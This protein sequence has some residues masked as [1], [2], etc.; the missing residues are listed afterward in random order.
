MTMKEFIK[1]KAELISAIADIIA[2]SIIVFVHI[3]NLY[4]CIVVA[5]T[6]GGANNFLEFILYIFDQIKLNGFKEY[7]KGLDL[8]IFTMSISIVAL[9]TM[10]TL[11]CKRSL[12]LAIT[13]GMV[14]VI[15]LLMPFISYLGF[16]SLSLI[17]TSFCSYNFYRLIAEKKNN[18]GIKKAIL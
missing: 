14:L 18:L 16:T 12:D 11:C 13:Y 1:S 3:G 17:F 9:I 10:I 15:A 4:L 2:F 8:F 5:P 6:E 7:T